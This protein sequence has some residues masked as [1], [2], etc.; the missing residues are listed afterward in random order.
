MRK[1]TLGL[2]LLLALAAPI[3]VTAPALAAKPVKL[4]LLRLVCNTNREVGFDEVF[5]KV[6][7]AIVFGPADINQGQT[8]ALNGVPKQ[9]FQQTINVELFED[10]GGLN[11]DDFLGAATISR[12]LAGDGEQSVSFTEN[13]ADYTLFFKVTKR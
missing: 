10:D 9:G 6:N 2:L 7:G 11:Q 1:V 4:K 12:N 13:G 8:L 5:V 3:A